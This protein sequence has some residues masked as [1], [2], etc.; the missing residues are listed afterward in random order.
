MTVAGT[1]RHHWRIGDLIPGQAPHVGTCRFCGAQRKFTIVFAGE[2]Y[3]EPIRRT[4][5]GL[6]DLDL[7]PLARHPTADES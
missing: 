2:T 7:L 3:E 1:C 4:G 6:L 5:S